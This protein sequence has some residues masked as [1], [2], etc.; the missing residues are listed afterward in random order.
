MMVVAVLSFFTRPPDQAMGGSEQLD[1]LRVALHRDGEA[2]R[3]EDL[4][5]RVADVFEFAVELVAV[6]IEEVLQALEQVRREV[7]RVAGRIAVGTDR[8]KPVREE[9]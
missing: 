8:V 9:G 4:V 7:R 5:E 6:A 1:V 3:R 2:G